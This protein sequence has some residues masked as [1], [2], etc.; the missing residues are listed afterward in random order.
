MGGTRSGVRAA[1][2]S[3]IE[4][5]FR[6]RRVRCRERINL[7]PTARNLEYARRLRA[8]ILLEIA[9]GRFDYAKHF[10]ESPRATRLTPNAGGLT[11]VEDALDAWLERKRA[12]LEHSTII[13]YDRAIK[14]TLVPAFGAIAIR[15]LTRG[16]VVQWISEQRAS[17]KRL[18]NVLTP[19]RQMLVDEMNFE[20]IATNPCADL[21]V[22]RPRAADKPDDIDPF[23][24]D[25]LRTILD[26]AI[27]QVRNLIQF[28]AWS[29]LRTSELIALQWADVDLKRSLAR[30]RAA[31]VYGKR[32]ATKTKAGDRAVELLKPAADALKAQQAHTLLKGGV[33]FENPATSKAWQTDKQ[34]REWNWRPLLKAAGVR[35]RYP[36]QLRHTFASTMLSAGENVFWV[37]KQMGHTDPSMT[38][39]K[40]TR[41]IPSVMPDAGRKAEAVWV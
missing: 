16:V 5:D 29:G 38:S 39:R 37:A 15:D 25:E 1:S 7:A 26:H 36:Y 41:F 27:G 10:P 17:A 11:S 23:S 6:Y 14:H 32:K 20:H 21:L 33:V 34:I 12:E 24:P 40:Y 3:T 28:A 18:N 30:V 8:S 31:F 35:Y 4:I 13:G 2:E 9:Q 19:L 22:K